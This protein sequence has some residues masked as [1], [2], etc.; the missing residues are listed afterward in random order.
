MPVVK[1]LFKDATELVVFVSNGKINAMKRDFYQ[2][3]LFTDVKCFRDLLFLSPVGV[4]F[5]I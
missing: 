3:N 1:D 4:H 2:Q 5:I